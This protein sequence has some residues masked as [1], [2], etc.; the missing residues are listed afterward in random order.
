MLTLVKWTHFGQKALCSF[1]FSYLAAANHGKKLLEPDDKTGQTF[2]TVSALD[3]LESFLKAIDSFLDALP[4]ETV[5]L[6]L[7][8]LDALA[9][10][11][12]NVPDNDVAKALT[13]HMAAYNDLS[14]FF[15][16]MKVDLPHYIGQ[17]VTAFTT[18][19][20]EK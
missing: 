3:A 13:P 9:S 8:E 20:Y 2:M 18:P 12:A 14:T 15:R 5:A 7:T 11:D 16:A 10:A 17:L 1:M 4:Q 6:C 19:M